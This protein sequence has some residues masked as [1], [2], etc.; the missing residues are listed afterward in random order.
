MRVDRRGNLVLFASVLCILI[1]MALVS[2]SYLSSTDASTT[3]HLVR[4]LQATALAESI[5]VTVEGRVNSGPWIKRFWLEEALASAPPGATGVV[6]LL[7]FSKTS[8]HFPSVGE[9][10][11]AP[12][13]AYTGVVKDLDTSARVYR[14]YVEVTIGG[15]PYTF[16]WDKRYDESLMGALNRDATIMDK[17]IDE[18]ASAQDAPSDQLIDVIKEEAKQPPADSVEER[19]KDI[20]GKLHDD[21]D[22]VR[23]ATTVASEPDASPEPLPT[24]EPARAGK[25]G[26]RR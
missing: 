23:G 13:W 19:Y 20:L 2:L 22:T 1:F 12:D 6:P 11:V 5:A 10:L 26:K 3:A 16:S 24:P 14:I 4:E 17:R 7:T 25:K 9:G 8:G 18:D 21:E 15:E